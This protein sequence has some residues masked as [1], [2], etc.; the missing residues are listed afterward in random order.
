MREFNRLP[1]VDDDPARLRTVAD[2]VYIAQF[3]IDHF[4]EGESEMTE[5]EVAPLRSFVKKWEGCTGRS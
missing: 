1:G 5:A 2:L 3:E 4:N